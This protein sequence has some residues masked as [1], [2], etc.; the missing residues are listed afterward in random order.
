MRPVYR[1]YVDESGDHTYGKKEEAP[2]IIKHGDKK[3]VIGTLD[4][5]P[6]LEK[7]DKR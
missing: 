5:Y 1:L 6:Q 4:Y 2:F 3:E 7:D